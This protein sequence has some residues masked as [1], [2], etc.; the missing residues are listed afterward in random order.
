MGGKSK[1]KALIEKTK[2]ELTEKEEEVV[3]LKK[4]LAKLE[5]Q[6]DPYGS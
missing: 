5:E 3:F 4:L 2:K 1:F 6:E